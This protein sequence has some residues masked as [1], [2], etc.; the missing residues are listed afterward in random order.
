MNLK[1][2]LI[3]LLFI[4]FIPQ[5]TMADS[6]EIYRYSGKKLS[7]EKEYSQPLFLSMKEIEAKGLNISDYNI[8]CST[9]LDK[10]ENKYYVF[11]YSPQILNPHRRGGHGIIEVH[12]N[13]K[14]HEI[15]SHFSR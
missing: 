14:T 2:Y 13:A 9:Y 6:F 4:F 3:T 15:K 5:N 1:K 11:T 7:I 8:S 10:T 12:I